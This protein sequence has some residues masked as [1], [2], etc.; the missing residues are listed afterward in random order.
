MNKK[1]TIQTIK[2][3][4]FNK[5]PF[6]CITA[7]DSSVAKIV[8]S[9]DIPIILVGDSASMVMMGNDSTIPIT[10]EEMLVFVKSVSKNTKNAL[11][12][13]DMPFM[14]YQASKEIAIKN[15]G[16]FIK[17]GGANAVKIEGGA[18]VSNKIK[19]LVNCGIPVMGHIGLLPQS[20]NQQSGYNL[21]GKNKLDADNLVND[22]LSVQN[23]G[24]FSIVLEGMPSRLSKK[25]TQ[26]LDIPTIGIGAGPHC[27]GQ[28]QVFHDI[29]G[30]FDTFVPK[31]SKQYINLSNHIKKSLINY[32]NDVK[33]KTFPSKEHYQN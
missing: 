17:A 2:K 31:H 26:S 10:I 3:L 13:A 16:T 24:A 4:K 21:Q 25:I 32:I 33:N 12:V 20:I 30:L 8:D 29:M 7:Y 18:P 27:N 19:A 1:H 5:E 22:A 23:A 15:A 28:I 9:L 11:V 14:S 6:C